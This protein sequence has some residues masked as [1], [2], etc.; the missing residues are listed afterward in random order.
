MNVLC[1]ALMAS[2]EMYI[3]S[4]NVVLITFEIYAW[5]GYFWWACISGAY[6][7]QLQGQPIF[8]Y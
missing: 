6:Q 2:I 8:N 5:N 4:V 7:F 1:F 3:F